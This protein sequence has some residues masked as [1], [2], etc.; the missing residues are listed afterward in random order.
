[1]GGGGRR[2]PTP[3]AWSEQA[4]CSRGLDVLAAAFVD[5]VAPPDPIS[6]RALETVVGSGDVVELAIG[7]GQPERLDPAEVG[8]EGPDPVALAVDSQSQPARPA[9]GL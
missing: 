8:R 5:P 1:M 2:L 3:S 9:R 4:A 7:L 6:A